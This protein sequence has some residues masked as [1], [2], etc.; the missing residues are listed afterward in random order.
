MF[1][2]S[3]ELSL[4]Y[5]TFAPC[6]IEGTEVTNFSTVHQWRSIRSGFLTVA[7]LA[8]STSI[9]ARADVIY[10]YTGQNFTSA[11]GGFTTDDSL[12]GQFSLSSAL[13]S[14]LNEADLTPISL[15]FSAGPATINDSNLGFNIFVVSTDAT[16]AIT[17]WLIAVQNDAND[18]SLVTAGG[19]LG[20][21][22]P[23]DNVDSPL[24]SAVNETAGSFSTMP[25]AV[26]P[27]PSGIA[28]VVIGL[29][30]VVGLH[31]RR[32]I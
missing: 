23:G 29:V 5:G 27:E 2:L 28:L 26:V 31:R 17:A 11:S 21:L 22:I 24:G 19:L 30:G 13:A 3:A 14:N 6:R 9:S 10:H 15:S 8:L 25:G 16:G 4:P 32:L 1:Q 20:G 18:T 12:N 7:I